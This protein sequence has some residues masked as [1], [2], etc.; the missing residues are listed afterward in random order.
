MGGILLYPGPTL[1][2][3]PV[4]TLPLNYPVTHTLT[5]VNYIADFGDMNEQ[6]VGKN[7]AYIRA[8][9]EGQV[10][11]YGGRN[12]FGINLNRK[13][14]FNA[15]PT[16]VV[17]QLWAFYKARKAGLE[18]FYFYNPVEAVPDPTGIATVG[19]YLVRFQDQGLSREQIIWKLF[20]SAVNLIEVRY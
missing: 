16:R 1:D 11:E 15:E 10:T 4:F 9:G 18:Q 7:V 5:F 19:R 20:N 14:Y 13:S 12:T 17:N 3:I 2:P 8:D 6:R